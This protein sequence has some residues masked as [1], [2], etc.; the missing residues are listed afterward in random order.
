MSINQ[1][2]KNADK[3][4]KKKATKKEIDIEEAFKLY[5]ESQGCKVFKLVLLNLRGWPD[6]TIL[7]PGGKIFFIEF[8]RDI[9]KEL[10][11]NQQRYKNILEKLG[12]R[13]YRADSYDVARLHLHREIGLPL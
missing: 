9:K 7:C 12:F 13:Y 11:A 3:T 4:T 2:L 6:R 8:K 1:F 5:A 10:T